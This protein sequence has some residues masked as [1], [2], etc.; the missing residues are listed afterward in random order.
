[1]SVVLVTGSSSGFGRAI[2]AAFAGRGDTVFGAS[3]H[4]VAGPGITPVEL[5]VT[6]AGSRARALATVGDIDVLVNNAGVLE[7]TSWED[8]DEESLRRIFETNLFG[9]IALI[10]SVLPGLRERGRGRIVNV[11]A[12]GAIAPT[13][14]LGAYSASKHA[15]AAL[16]ASLDTEV[17]PFGIRVSAVLPGAF[18][19][20]ILS[21]APARG[22]GGPYAAAVDDYR[23]GLAQRLE[24][25]GSDYSRV[26]DAVVAAATEDDPRLRYLVAGE[27]MTTLLGPIVE[28]LEALPR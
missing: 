14:F 26:V 13:A 28:Q 4:P 6:D 21:R 25:G 23:A 8:Q 17:R 7:V 11:A 5:D 22:T 18:E 12:I 2:S 27:R 10:R 15:L 3:R 16:S 1:V 24:D 19:T 9:P 20:E